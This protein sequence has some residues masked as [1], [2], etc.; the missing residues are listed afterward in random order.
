MDVKAGQR[1]RLV[2]HIGY[3]IDHDDDRTVEVEGLGAVRVE[4]IQPDNPFNPCNHHPLFAD[5]VGEVIGFDHEL[6]EGR[7]ESHVIL[8]FPHRQ[9]VNHKPGKAPED[10]EHEETGT[11][12][13]WSCLAS[14]LADTTKFEYV[15]DAENPR[16][17][18]PAPAWVEPVG[19]E[20]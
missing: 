2:Q 10:V 6:R 11:T 5:Q 12:R 1:Y 4:G 7:T 16:D 20:A 8:E 13:N 19:E 18:T 14:D 15:G 9:L 3:D 17:L